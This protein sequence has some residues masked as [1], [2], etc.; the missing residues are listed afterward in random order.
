MTAA[1]QVPPGP[2]EAQVR[3][4][5][6]RLGLQ[7]QHRLRHGRVPEELRRTLAVVHAPSAELHALLCTS[8]QQPQLLSR[9]AADIG[10][11]YMDEQLHSMQADLAQSLSAVQDSPGVMKLEDRPRILA[12]IRHVLDGQQDV[13]NSLLEPRS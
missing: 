7:L 4:A 2:R 13:L 8:K 3:E 5:L 1:T 11:Q 12:L 9:A 10:W 6:Q